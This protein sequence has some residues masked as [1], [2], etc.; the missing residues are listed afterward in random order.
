M[1][2][3]N[4]Y[5]RLL[6]R[7]IFAGGK[8]SAYAAIIQ[9]AQER[10]GGAAYFCNAHML[11]EA[12]RSQPLAAALAAAEWTFPDGMPVVAAMKLLGHRRTERVAGMDAVPELCAQCDERRLSVYFHGC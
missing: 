11:I 5:G 1:G 8:D 7:N 10:L 2:S 12:L 4:E 3:A 6:G 9:A